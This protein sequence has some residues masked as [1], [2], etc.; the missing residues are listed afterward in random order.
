MERKYLTEWKRFLTED[1][2]DFPVTYDKLTEKQKQSF[3]AWADE[4]K[5][6]MTKE[7]AY[8]EYG[9]TEWWLGSIES[10]G[11]GQDTD[12]GAIYS[13]GDEGE[14]SKIFGYEL[15]NLMIALGVLLGPGLFRLIWK[16]GKGE[17]VGLRTSKILQ[18]AFPVYDILFKFI[19]SGGKPF[20]RLVRGNQKD[21]QEGALIE[22]MT[23]LSGKQS[24]ETL[25]K[26]STKEEK[27]L[28]KQLRSAA[29][30]GDITISALLK[31][32]TK[33]LLAD[34]TKGKVTVD[35]LKQLLGKNYK[36]TK[37]YQDAAR[38]QL[39][40]ARKYGVEYYANAQRTL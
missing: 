25:V 32:I 23:Y 17:Y 30:R 29:M 39:E 14:N 37:L 19:I 18:K 6:S 3:D 31:D 27:E 22:L 38:I 4:N 24:F 10:G 20:I 11:L 28:L 15:T 9:Y 35:V 33:P 21:K 12:D 2:K 8:N 5:P 40:K 13:L 34:I 36:K 16:G 7:N 26:A 1:D